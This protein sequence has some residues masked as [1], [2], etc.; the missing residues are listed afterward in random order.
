[1]VIVYQPKI[2][3][4]DGGSHFYKNKKYRRLKKDKNVFQLFHFSNSSFFL[5]GLF[6]KMLNVSSEY[7]YRSSHRKSSFKKKC[8]KNFCK[9][10]RK[11]PVPNFL[12]TKP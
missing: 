3:C 12:L 9:I 1:M 7:S 8:S 6:Q 4:K 11:T 10:H 2:K 5:Y